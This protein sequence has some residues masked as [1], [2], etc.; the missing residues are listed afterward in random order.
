[1]NKCMGSLR[2]CGMHD[3]KSA[4]IDGIFVEICA[5]VPY[6]RV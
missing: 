4:F 3:I 1:M 2:R 5:S 6:A